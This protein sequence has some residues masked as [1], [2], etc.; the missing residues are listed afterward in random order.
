MFEDGTAFENEVRRIARLLWPTAEFGGAAIED[1]RERDGVFETE[2][3][4]HIVE[5]TMSRSKRKA[6]EDLEK[7][8]KLARKLG[9]RHRQKFIKGWFVTLEEP[10]AAQRAVFRN[11]QGRIVAVSFEQFRSRLVDA[12]SYLVGRVNYPFGSV[13]DPETGAARTSLDYVPLDVVGDDGSLHSVEDICTALLNG[14]RLVLVGDYGAGKS[15][16]VREVFLKLSRVFE[17]GR[18]LFFPLALNLRDHHGQ[19]DPVEALERHA[20]QVGFQRPADLVRGWRAGFGLLLLDGFDEIA[21][22]GWA[23]KTKK[24]RDLR[25]RSMELVRAF[26]RD[27]PRSVG[28]LLAGRQH[29]F[30]SLKEMGESLNLGKESTLLNVSEFSEEQVKTYLA[31]EGW[32]NPIPEWIPSRPL[33]LGYLAARKLLQQTLEVEAGSGRA[34]GW[35]SLLDRICER[36]AEI[37]AGIDPGTVRRLLGFLAT[38]AR[39]SADGLGPL[40]PEQIIAGF[41]SV[42]GYPPDD[43]GIVLLQRMPGLGGHSSQD[44]SRVFIDVDFAEAACGGTIAD[45]MENPYG[46]NLESETWQSSM[47]SLGAAVAAC[48]AHASGMKHG[49]MVAALRRAHD[50][51]KSDT[52]CAD[53]V[54]TMLVAGAQYEGPAVFVKEVIIPELLLEEVAQDLNAIQFQDCIIGRLELPPEPTL[55]R[56]PRFLRCHFGLVEGRT[57]ERDMPPEVFS[58]CTFDVF[59]NPAQ[60]TNAILGLGLPLA[61][62]VLLTVLKKLYAQRGSGRRESALYRGLD[63]RGRESVPEALDLLRRHGFAIKSRQ[64]DQIVWHTSKPS[65]YRRRAIS[66]LAAPNASNDP[67]LCESRTLAS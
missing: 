19:T 7:L 16:T 60:T 10:T 6:E 67:L 51:P 24:L 4:V 5:C 54:Q 50:L 27:T 47:S 30:D 37:E 42:C 57:G 28:V 59:E 22:A 52:L 12:K 31:K 66:I 17:T 13:R 41:A 35:N 26:L 9:S 18:S 46:Q 49:Q 38:L 40:S 65:E 3:F 23:G 34:V 56:H 63:A 33:L 62:K 39:N 61:T 48:R 44:G 11:V 2:E 20:R 1:G 32:T 15:A 64:G 21:T 55:P 45:F 36:E 43:R 58:E 53:V 14:M 29:F 8:Q 25:F